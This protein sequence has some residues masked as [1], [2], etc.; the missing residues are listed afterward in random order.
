MMTERDVEL[1]AL[2]HSAEFLAEMKEASE[3]RTIVAG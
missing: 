1:I 3:M 2:W